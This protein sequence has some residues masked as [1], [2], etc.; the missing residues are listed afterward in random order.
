MRINETVTSVNVIDGDP[1]QFSR[2]SIMTNGTLLFYIQTLPK[3]EEKPY[4]FMQQYPTIH[5]GKQVMLQ[6]HK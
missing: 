3:L 1:K 5:E 4:R 6:H 2:L